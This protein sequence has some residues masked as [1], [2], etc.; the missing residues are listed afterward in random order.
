MMND[1]WVVTDKR[2]GRVIC[3]CGEEQD[4][5]R[6]IMF[7]QNRVY[8]KQKFIMDQVITISSSGIKELP[9]QQALPAGRIEQ[10][11]SQRVRLSEGCGKPLLI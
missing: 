1:Y 10:L 9:G 3:Y 6:M 5:V 4:A 7:D 11:N 2:T 8:R